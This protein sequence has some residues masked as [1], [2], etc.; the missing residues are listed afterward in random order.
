MAIVSTFVAVPTCLA[1]PQAQMDAALSFL[2]A[3]EFE[4]WIRSPLEFPS[5]GI[6]AIDGVMAALKETPDFQSMR[7]RT[8]EVMPKLRTKLAEIYATKFREADRVRP[9]TTAIEKRD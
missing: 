5:V 6:P 1:V 8:T 2:D 4:R 7:N 9:R 3:T